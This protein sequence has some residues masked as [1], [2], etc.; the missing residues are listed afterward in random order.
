MHEESADLHHNGWAWC[1]PHVVQRF[2]VVLPCSYRLCRCAA[3]RWRTRRATCWTSPA[4]SCSPRASTTASASSR[5]GGCG[6]RGGRAVGEGG[7]W[8]GCCSRG[9]GAGAGGRWP[10]LGSPWAACPCAGC[11]STHRPSARAR[12]KRPAAPPP[13]PRARR[14][15]WRRRAAWR[16]AWWARATPSPARAWTR[17]A[18]RRAG[19]ASRWAA[20]PTWTTS[21]SWRRAWTATGR[22]C[23]PTCRPSGACVRVCGRQAACGGSGAQGFAGQGAR[24][25]CGGARRRPRAAAAAGAPAVRQHPRL[26]HR[27]PASPMPRPSVPCAARRCCSGGACWST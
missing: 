10:A 5:W 8:C 12:R 20:S 6:W 21:A 16:R 19:P 25:L 18:A 13:R 27:S 24:C 26:T 3:R 4:T 17:S 22:A 9:R 15:C 23:R 2:R 1:F 14:W 7:E 11:H